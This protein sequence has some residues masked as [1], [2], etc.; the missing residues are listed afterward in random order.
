MRLFSNLPLTT[1]STAKL[2]AVYQLDQEVH[3]A[4]LD[5]IRRHGENVLIMSSSHYQPF[6]KLSLEQK[7]R[8]YVLV[9]LYSKEYE[10]TF[11]TD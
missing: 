3:H 7:L 10:I 5:N 8:S 6:K 9:K 4:E 11:L 2:R 1:L